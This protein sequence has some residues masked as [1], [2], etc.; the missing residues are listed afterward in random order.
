MSTKATDIPE[1]VISKIESIYEIDHE[2]QTV[3]VPCNDTIDPVVN[4]NIQ[5]LKKHFGYSV[6]YTL[7]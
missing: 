6:Q 3:F 2:T 1:S 7:F 5:T 4:Y